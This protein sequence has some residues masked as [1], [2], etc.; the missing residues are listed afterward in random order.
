MSNARWADVI[1]WALLAVLLVLALTS[2][3]T[4]TLKVVLW[5][6]LNIL[7]AAA[8]RFVMLTGELNIA[9]AAF[10]GVGAYVAA[11]LTAWYKL[12]FF[13]SLLIGGLAP[14]LLS[15]LFGYVTLRTKG[16]YFM[17]ISFAFTEVLRLIYTQTE[18]IGGNSGM[19]G[20]YPPR[21]LDPYYSA[22]V[23]A[24]V[25]ALLAVFFW[26]ERGAFGK[27][28]RAIQN[29][30][31]VTESVGIDVLKMKVIC[32]AI[33]SFAAGV[34]GA[35]FAH[36]NRVISPGDFS[37][38]VAVYALA[39]VKIGGETQFSGAII[40]A[41]LL[42]LLNQYVITF[43]HYEHLFFGGAIVVA[44]L[45]LPNGLMGLFERAAI[46]FGGTRQNAAP[47]ARGGH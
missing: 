35:L 4:Y 43:G 42:T 47:A 28:L 12:P 5:I 13:L 34:G 10:W 18:S 24:I 2:G 15:V 11:I 25:A 46:A 23:V 14:M 7:A 30:D 32:L 6:S 3:D 9:T 29:N 21:W 8:L 17:L 40:G 16:P 33:A 20:I 19:I 27:L 31:A 38:L 1:G 45:V 41:V 22:I 37:F 26:L 44:M 39:Y 36:A